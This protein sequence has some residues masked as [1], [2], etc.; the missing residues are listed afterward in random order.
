MR[1]AREGNADLVT[2]NIHVGSTLPATYSSLGKVLLAELDAIKEGGRS[3][4]SGRHL[5]RRV[6]VGVEF[7]LALTLLAG[8]GVAAHAFIRT[9]S[10]D[11]GFRSDHLLTLELPVR[12]GRFT[13]PEAVETVVREYRAY[14]RKVPLKDGD[15]TMEHTGVV[16]L[17]DGKGRFVRPFKVD[18][19]PA[20]A[21]MDLLKVS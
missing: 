12:R 15:Y 6:L 19:E 21:A 9:M 5:L 14:A 4:G 7:A 16:Y 11:L 1:G 13:T 3:I 8:G 2:A 17:M 20:A 18:R 10:V